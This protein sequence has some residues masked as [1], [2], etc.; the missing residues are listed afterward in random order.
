MTPMT[1]RG[2]ASAAILLVLTGIAGCT[3]GRQDPSDIEP[4][5]T[6]G[7]AQAALLRANEVAESYRGKTGTF[8]GLTFP[9]SPSAGQPRVVIAAAHRFSIVLV[10][11][12]SNA[13]FCTGRNLEH[14]PSLAWVNLGTDPLQESSPLGSCR[15]DG[16]E[17]TGWL[18]GTF[19]HGRALGNDR[20]WSSW[21]YSFPLPTCE[22]PEVG[23]ESLGRID[24][25]S[26]R[27]SSAGPG[28][29]V[30]RA[31]GPFDADS[32]ALWVKVTDDC[33]VAYRYEFRP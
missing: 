33:Y 31:T 32:D 29:E 9:Q 27:L 2:A 22:L 15:P 5:I 25:H 16:N 1:R 17:P 18:P 30:F 4:V 19:I 24:M 28:K 20:Y 6:D 21:S 13:R 10:A 8:E 23:L 7:Q 26:H 11:S 3:R 12:S 14:L